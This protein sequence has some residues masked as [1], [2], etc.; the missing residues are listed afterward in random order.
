M[1]ES[2]TQSI[3]TYDVASHTTADQSLR[4][5]NESRSAYHIRPKLPLN[6]AGLWLILAAQNA[7]V[8]LIFTMADLFELQGI[9]GAVTGGWGLPQR[10]NQVFGIVTSSQAI[11]TRKP[12]PA[13]RISVAE[14]R[15]LAI[16]AL[17]EAEE[18][19]QDERK[20]E[21]AF[22]AALEDEL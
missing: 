14:A 20:R 3:A 1:I 13:R 10:V 5:L 6:Y 12:E 9:N 17:L 2:V 4:R 7:S 16:T 18:R 15:R 11:Q 21:S 22:W 19:R 8:D